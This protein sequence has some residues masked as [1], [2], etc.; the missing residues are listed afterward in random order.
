MS[1]LLSGFSGELL[2]FPLNVVKLLDQL[3]GLF[4]NLAF[5][6]HMQVVELPPSMGHAANLSDAL[7][8]AGLVAT[9]V[10]AHQF[11]LPAFKEGAGIGASAD[12]GE[13]IDH[14]F[15]RGSRGTAVG[16]DVSAMGF[17][18]TRCQHGYW[19][20]IGVENRVQKQLFS[21]GIDQWLQSNAAA[22][23]PFRQG[24]AGDGES[25][26]SKDL[27]L[28][29]EWQV[30]GVFG[31]QQVGQQ[32]TGGDALV[33]DLRGHRCLGEAFAGFTGPLAADM[34]LYGERTRDVVELFTDIFADALE[35]AA[36]GALSAVRFL[37]RQ[38]RWQW[39]AFGLV[40][41]GFWLAIDRPSPLHL[42]SRDIGV[43]QFV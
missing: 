21:Q 29:V 18:F 10:V 39:R 37:A 2:G 7:V 5:I 28:P 42:D 14:G 43:H 13:V 12:F 33:D 34:T 9:V 24:G 25:G 30:I 22:A 41:L 4:G 16:P 6:R 19:G 8:E 20:F 11:A 3:Q 1:E 32:T 38:L 17:L 31:N 40:F 35:L 27:F 23:N 26:L 15:H 36:A